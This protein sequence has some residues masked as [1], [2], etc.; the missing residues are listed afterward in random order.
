M[1]RE[2]V[3]IMT[4]NNINVTED[5]ILMLEQ[6]LLP[7]NCKFDDD[8]R[9]FIKCWES[10]EVN[11]CPGSGKT[12]VLLAKL[13]ILADRMP[14]ENGGGI[15]VLSHTNVAIN[16]IKSKLAKDSNLILCYPNFVGTLQAFVDRFIV[17]PCLRRL[18]GSRVRLMDN[19]SYA[20]SLYR[21]I[22]SSGCFKNIR[23]MLRIKYQQ[24]GSRYSNV[25]DLVSDL[26]LEDGG[27][28]LP[29][30]KLLA[31]NKTPSAGEFRSAVKVLLREEGILRYE[32]AFR[33]ALSVLTGFGGIYSDLLS[34]RFKYVFVDEYQD[35]NLEQR[36]VIDQIFQ[37]NKTTI[38]KIGDVDQSIFNGRDDAE[39]WRVSENALSLAMSN[40]YGQETA[41]LLSCLR[42][43]CEKIVSSKGLLGQ[44]PV[45]IV[46]EDNRPDQVLPEFIKILNDKQ[47]RDQQGVYKVIGKVK[48][49]KGLKIG[50]Y[51]E[52]YNPEGVNKANNYWIYL[53]RIRKAIGGGDLCNAEGVFGEL[54]CEI[55]RLCGFKNNDTKY[56]FQSIGQCMEN[57]GGIDQYRT[58]I[59]DLASLDLGVE[60]FD[61]RVRDCVNSVLKLT[62]EDVF[63]LLP[64]YF[65]EHS[66]EDWKLKS[67]NNIYEDSVGRQIAF[68]TV[69]SVKGETH[70][71]TLYVET[72]ESRGSDLGR[73]CPLFEGK[74]LKP[75]NINEYS[76]RCVCVGMS[77]PRFLLCVA[78]RRKTFE[79]H[80][81]A[82]NGWEIHEM[83]V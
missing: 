50:D 7:K 19:R 17:I 1:L 59:L 24:L 5:E 76:R 2:V 40:R 78:I 61:C 21:L 46:F 30:G 51:W 26:Y 77:R 22:S 57:C 34:R 42:W 69:H 12:T 80:K 67:K 28:F 41:D 70:D 55:L 8:A 58:K 25:L 31:N 54:L 73:V 15:C 79:K 32:D 37:Q 64:E 29:K 4:H 82:F 6:L 10:R 63:S 18:C 62:C 27:L 74:K 52:G 43:N 48:S 53:S 38:F 14:M 16:E 35:C 45:L 72:E 33:Y 39:L 83:P 23:S 47:I 75:T 49:L 60:D 3:V 13:K 66:D 44:V 68:D 36:K 9:D 81:N 71:V 11:A 65:F 56:G 20:Y